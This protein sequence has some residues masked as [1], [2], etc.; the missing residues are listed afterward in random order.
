MTTV[1]LLEKRHVIKK[2][3]VLRDKTNPQ[4]YSNDVDPNSWYRFP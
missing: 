3:Q 1:L 2:E 4:K